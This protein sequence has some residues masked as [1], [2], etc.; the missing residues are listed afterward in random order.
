MSG[1]H[2]LH[3]NTQPLSAVIVE[4]GQRG[5]KISDILRTSVLGLEEQNN[6][7][8]QVGRPAGGARAAECQDRRIVSSRRQIQVSPSCLSRKTSRTN[9]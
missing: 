6:L 2:T 7:R 5:L 9:P 3:G 8:C 4:R 1:V